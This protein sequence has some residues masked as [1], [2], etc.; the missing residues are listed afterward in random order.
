MKRHDW[1]QDAEDSFYDWQEEEALLLDWEGC[2]Q[3]DHYWSVRE[4]CLVC[5]NSMFNCTCDLPLLEKLYSQSILRPYTPKRMD[6]P[7]HIQVRPLGYVPE[8]KFS[9]ASEFLEFQ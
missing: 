4:I 6:Y 8:A 9:T 7:R 3:S 2:D 5:G 1:F